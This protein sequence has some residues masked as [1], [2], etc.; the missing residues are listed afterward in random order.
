[1]FEFLD[2]FDSVPDDS[3]QQQ[4]EVLL[5]SDLLCMRCYSVIRTED[6]SSDPEEVSSDSQVLVVQ[7]SSFFDD[8]IRCLQLSKSCD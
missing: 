4:V 3:R 5:F 7:S 6:D 1:M 2:E 8:S